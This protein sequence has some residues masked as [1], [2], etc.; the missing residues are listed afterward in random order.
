M[1]RSSSNAKSELAEVVGE[2]RRRVG[3]TQREVAERAGTSVA[4]IRDL[5]QGRVTAPRVATLRRLGDALGLSASE[6]EGLLAL[7]Q[8]GPGPGSALWIQVLGPLAVAASGTDVDPGSARQRSLLGLLALSPN[9][10]VGRDTLI[11]A[12]WGPA[13]PPTAADLLQTRMS[14]LR[15]RLVAAMRPAH[16]PARLLVSSRG[17]YLLSVTDQ[18]LDLLAFRRRAAQA[19]RARASGELEQACRYFAEAVEL[20]RGAPLADLSAF[21]SLPAVVAL[22]KERRAVVVD[23]AET[24]AELGR[25]E[26]VLPLLQEVVDHDPLH[27]TAHAYLILA[28]AGS[29]QQAAAL[30][31][32]DAI[33]RRLVDE[34]GVDPGPALLN[35]QQRVLRQ[36]VPRS[37]TAPVVAHRQLPPDIADFTGRAEELNVLRERLPSVDRAPV[38]YSIQ[39]MGGVGKTRLAIRFAHEL[40]ATGDHADEQLYVDLRGH[41]NRSP[42][43]PFEVLA[44]FLYL[45]GVP[46]TQI[47]FDMAGRVALYR[48]RL[49]GKKA[50]VLLDNAADAEQVLPLLPDGSGT[51]VL[52]TSRRMLFLDG[53]FTVPLDVFDR[54]DAGELMRKI[55]G[56]Q[57]MDAERSAAFEVIDLCGGLPLAVALAAR[58]L[59]TR[60]AWTVGDLAARLRSADDRIGELAAGTRRVRAAFDLSYRAL[61][62]TQRGLF[63]MLGLQ[64]GVEF[65]VEPTAA[66]IG[67]D[68]GRTRG[69]LDGLV[70][71][72]LVTTATGGRYRLHDLLRGY[73]QDLVNLEEPE[74]R[75]RAAQIRL[76]DFYLLTANRAAQRLQAPVG[77]VA[78][79][80]AG[81]EDGPSFP[82]AAEAERW[83][84]SEFASLTASIQLAADLGM[85]DYGW[86]LVRSMWTFVNL[87][88]YTQ[89]WE[90]TLRVAL[91]TTQQAGLVEGEA[92]SRMYLGGALLHVGRNAE[93]A[94]H[95]ERSLAMHRRVGNRAMEIT[96]LTWL[97]I[98]GFRLGKLSLAL[99]HTYAAAD[100]EPTEELSRKAVVHNNA[101]FL[102]VLLGQI[103][104]S[105]VEY[106]F[107]LEL[108]RKAGNRAV[109]SLVLAN[110]GDCYRRTGD[111]QQAISYLQDALSISISS[112]RRPA[113]G[114]VRQRLGNVY[115]ALGNHRKALDLLTEALRILWTVGVNGAATESELLIDLALAHRD[116]GKVDRATEY[117]DRG[118]TLAR[119]TGERYQIARGLG[120]S[121]GIHRLRGE[122]GLAH[123]CGNTADW[124]FDAMGV[125]VDSVDRADRG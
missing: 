11:E 22:A 116:S 106:N 54:E 119:E 51:L 9:V 55:V 21:Q 77:A 66:L 65:T 101:G 24:A 16:R 123:E 27:E 34:L 80:G 91:A 111:L 81:P 13:P 39:G 90:H 71:E 124:L 47:P 110:I 75:R 64:P 84:G 45:L 8:V 104:K 68:V 42:A 30:R 4:G 58:R 88:G 95:L 63:R 15:R 20:W 62:A 59:Q 82:T 96:C 12:V 37:E 114:Y 1:V 70:D 36:E 99:R 41:A 19:R 43:N 72:H 85:T 86:R 73:A 121:A 94:E 14:R 83:L 38:I 109:E 87:N 60:P 105:M 31:L 33:R 107:S 89:D 49:R 25:Y 61:D 50:L 69:L 113:E 23:F 3:L 29:G 93:A 92:V 117:V 40:V 18:Q 112:G 79:P 98:A 102:L 74:H 2:F 17:G 10:V 67:L 56:P 6:A 53:A 103:D 46:G 97:G 5:E 125:P 120:V 122:T 35:A 52:I 78:D 48:E 76:L 32:F 108:S 28:L 57:R 26:E 100:L 115:R 118:L 44:S 7:G